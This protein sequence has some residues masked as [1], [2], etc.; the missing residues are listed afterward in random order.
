MYRGRGAAVSSGAARGLSQVAGR[1]A[2][3]DG[4]QVER[5]SRRPDFEKERW[6][7]GT[8]NTGSSDDVRLVCSWQKRGGCFGYP[9]PDEMTAG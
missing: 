1:S 6:G 3:G 2:W 7:I 9:A 8:G 5:I 4:R